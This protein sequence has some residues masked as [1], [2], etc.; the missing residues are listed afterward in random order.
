MSTHAKATRNTIKAA[1]KN[2]PWVIYVWM[3]GL[4]LSGYFIGRVGLDSQPHPV[5]WAAGLAGAFIGYF[6][7][8]LWYRWQG[9]IP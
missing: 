4:G 8:W 2:W 1:H 3:I 9:D 6:V 7:G 5:H